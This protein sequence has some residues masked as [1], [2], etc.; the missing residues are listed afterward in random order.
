ML[1]VTINVAIATFQEEVWG[2]HCLPYRW[3]SEQNPQT[4]LSSKT[5]KREGF[6]NICASQPTLSCFFQNRIPEMG[7]T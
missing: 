4:F 7:K 1:V 5:E 3:A 2:I 6:S